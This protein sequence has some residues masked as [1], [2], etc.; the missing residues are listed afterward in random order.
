T[1]TQSSGQ[2][3]SLRRPG[4]SWGFGALPKGLTSVVVLRQ[5]ESAGHSLPPPTIPAGPETQTHNLQVHLQ[6][7]SLTIRPRL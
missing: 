4:S 3:F 5:E 1:H 2:P 6:S 7:N